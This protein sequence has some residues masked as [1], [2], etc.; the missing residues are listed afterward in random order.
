LNTQ[1]LCSSLDLVLAFGLNL[2]AALR[3]PSRGLAQAHGS[4]LGDRLQPC[5]D[6][7][8]VAHDGDPAVLHLADHGQPA[9][10]AD[11][12]LRTGAKP[13]LEIIRRPPE[14]INDA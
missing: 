9:V 4:R 6:I 10:D 3:E 8:G 2:N 5:G 13:A 7:D 14:T 1:R 12:Q 11:A